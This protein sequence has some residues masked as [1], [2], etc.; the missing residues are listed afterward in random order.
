MKENFGCS[1]VGRE[2]GGL[3]WRDAD[4]E[5]TEGARTGLSSLLVLK[6]RIGHLWPLCSRFHLKKNLWL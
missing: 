3:P 5:G 6:P 2:P 4:D 1:L